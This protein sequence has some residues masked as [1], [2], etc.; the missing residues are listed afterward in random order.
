MTLEASGAFLQYVYADTS[1]A[2]GVT[3]APDLLPLASLHGLGRLATVCERMIVSGYDLDDMQSALGI[4]AFGQSMGVAGD[5]LCR[6]AAA[7]IHEAAPNPTI[8]ES[9]V[10]QLQEQGWLSPEAAVRIMTPSRH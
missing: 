10:Q 3:H 4:F 9:S 8:L 1:D 5:R 7:A 2:V 6:I